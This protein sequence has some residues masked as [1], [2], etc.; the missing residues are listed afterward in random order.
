MSSSLIPE[1]PLLI[2]P[3]LAATIGLEETVL[4]QALADIMAHREGAVRDQLRWVEITDEELGAALPFWTSA[5]IRRVE[6]SLREL[7]LILRAAD[8]NRPDSYLYAVNQKTPDQMPAVPVAA[9]PVAADGSV[10]SAFRPAQRSGYLPADWQPGEEWL[11]QCRMHN[12]PDA[13]SLAQVPEFVGYW[14]DRGQTRFSWGNAFYKHVLR[15]WRQEQTERGARENATTMARDWMPSADAVEILAN[16]GV[17]LDFI[18]DAVP[19]FVLYWRER[20]EV[21]STWNAKFIEHIRRQWQKYSSSIGQDDIPRPIAE[22]WQPSPACFDILALAEIDEEYARGKVPEFVLYWR[23]S[24]HAR[25][26]WNTV[27]L[28]FI[29]QDWARRL[30]APLEVESSHAQHRS[31]VEEGQRRLEERLR[32]LADRS[33]AQN[34]RRW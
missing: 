14:R 6:A 4:L 22:D 19:E 28:Q 23:D 20:G 12:I 11:T 9:R 24:G 33:W 27:F 32:Q 2:S 10:H 25:A 16:A 29:K 31:P 13:F 26:S 8:T 18:E 3:T 17:P 34:A 15:R 21:T 1:R 7:G 5:D 30:K